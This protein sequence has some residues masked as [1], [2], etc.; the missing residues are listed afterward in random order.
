MI[1]ILGI[2]L[3]PV[4]ILYG[5]IIFVRNLFFDWG[6]SDSQ[7]FN[8]PVISIGNL[9][10]GGTGKTPM[11]GYL[12]NLL[13]NDRKLATLSRGYGRKTKGFIVASSGT[14][15]F[16]I[17]DEP[18]Q[19]KYKFPEIIVSVGEN[20]AKAIDALILNYHADL[21]LLDDAFQH[22]SV[23]AGLSILLFDYKDIYKMDFML[24]TGNLREW[25]SGKKRADVFVVTKCPPDLSENERE[26][27]KGILHPKSNQTVY[28][29]YIQ[30]EDLRLYDDIKKNSADDLKRY[31]VLLVSGIANPKP[32]IEYLKPLSKEVVTLTF[33]DHHAFDED[34]VRNIKGKFDLISNPNKIII[35]TEKDLMR[36]TD[37]SA[38]TLGLLNPLYY[39]PISTDF[40]EED[41]NK[42]DE[43]ILNYVRKN[44]TNS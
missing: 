36:L 18:K 9:V 37:L 7:K 25:K 41:K 34:D 17:G 1:K 39:I 2:I 21:I 4:S 38:E 14:K 42:F 12:V 31:S 30:Y 35:T 33:K 6:L 27:I 24:P 10:A 19:Y 16:L 8:I 28:F 29:S 15:S 40:F 26:K 20:R 23:V 3:F 44:K 11:T 32:L 13:K 22:R 5:L 43:Q